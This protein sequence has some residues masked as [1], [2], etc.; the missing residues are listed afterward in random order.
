MISSFN[1]SMICQILSMRHR[2]STK[3]HFRII[4]YTDYLALVKKIYPIRI[5]FFSDPICKKNFKSDP[6]WKKNSKM[7][8]F[9]FFFFFVFFFI[10]V[11]SNGGIECERDTCPTVT[12]TWLDSFFFNLF[13]IPAVLTDGIDWW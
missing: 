10:P 9:H 12:A 1:Y 11:V 8:H 13:F 2:C 3:L 5:F 7:T 6:L 4:I